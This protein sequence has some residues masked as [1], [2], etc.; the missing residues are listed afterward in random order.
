MDWIKIEKKWHQMAFR[1]QAA[2]KVTAKQSAP[3]PLQDAVTQPLA[4]PSET[5]GP[6]P[7]HDPKTA[8][9]AMA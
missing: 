9:R 2:G 8:A 7:A 3:S 5:P 4:K 6:R 1:L